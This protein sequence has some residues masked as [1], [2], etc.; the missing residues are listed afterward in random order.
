MEKQLGAA[1]LQ[2][3][4]RCCLVQPQYLPFITKSTE[5]FVLRE[6]VVC[7]PMQRLPPYALSGW[8]KALTGKGIRHVFSLGGAP[9]LLVPVVVRCAPA[10]V[11]LCRLTVCSSHQ[12]SVA[13]CLQPLLP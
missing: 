2:L 7:G 13:L 8:G 11:P 1:Q 3:D 9:F 4:G 5:S 6:R 12:G 10:A